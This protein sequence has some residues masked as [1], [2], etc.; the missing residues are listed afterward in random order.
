[1]KITKRQL[2]KLIRESLSI[3]FHKHPTDEEKDA[4]MKTLMDIFNVGKLK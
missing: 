2:S 4:M 1:V 3:E